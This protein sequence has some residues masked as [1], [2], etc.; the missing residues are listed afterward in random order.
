MYTECIYIVYTYSITST[1]TLQTH[2][3]SCIYSA[4]NTPPFAVL[5]KCS[6]H[7]ACLTPPALSSEALYTTAPPS[8]CLSYYTL[9][10]WP[11]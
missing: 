3:I 1:D 10:P 2:Y 8:V 7:R 9:G 6:K 11:E 5:S 4:Y